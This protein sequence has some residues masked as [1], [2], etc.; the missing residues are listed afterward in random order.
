MINS[1]MKKISEKSYLKDLD[2]I[3][4]SK[5]DSDIKEVKDISYINDSSLEHQLDIYYKS[6]N[7]LKPIL[8]DIHGGGFISGSKETDSLF[9]NYLAQRGFVVFCLNYRL[10]YPTINVFDQIKDI[11]DAVGWII[12]NAEKYEGNIKEMYI[13][14]HSAGAV[15]TIAESLLC[16]DKKMRA[17]FNIEERDYKYNGII[18]DC[19]VM[20]FYAKSIAYW[21]M[22]NMIFP[23]DYKKMAKYQYLLF[24]NNSKVSTLPKTILLTNEKDYL[25]KM[26]Y[27][28]KT[29]LDE[30]N[31]DNKLFDIGT[32]GHIGI[33]FK[34]YTEENQKLIDNIQDY[35]ACTS[36]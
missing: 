33:V 7:E 30:N 22:R 10:A 5:L 24:E 8:I 17:D 21:G 6:H 31:V 20:H 18:L 16:N 12:A 1:L 15:L 3:D 2:R 9:A 14:G 29:V 27:Y 34:I 4:L 23:K 11:S 32:D 13:A 26:T 36:I 35:F 25:R 28:F 19:G